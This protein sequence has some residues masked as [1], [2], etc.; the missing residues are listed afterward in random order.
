MVSHTTRNRITERV[1]RL[2]GG[3]PCRLQVAALPWRKTP[4]GVEVMLITSR[5]TGRW[6]LPKGWPEGSEQLFDTAAREAA[7]EAGIGGAIARFEIGSYFYSKVLSSGMERRCEVLV[8]PLE[9]DEVATA[10]PEKKQR[11]RKWFAPADAVSRVKEADLGELI[12]R[13]A[14]NPRAYA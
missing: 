13:F 10:W 4:T 8:F 5:D 9:V 7:E 3:K 2:F 12:A 14:K 6:V 1:R 11:D